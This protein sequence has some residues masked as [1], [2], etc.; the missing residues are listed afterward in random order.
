[1]G[2][3]NS[4]G[5]LLYRTGSAGLE[6]L[7]VHPGGPFWARRDDGAWSIPKGEFDATEAPEAAARREFAE[8]TGFAQPG[9]LVALPL[10]AQSRGK[11][12]HAFAAELDVDPS[13][14][15][16]NRFEIEWP[17]RSGR[18]QS[19]PEID[20]AGWFTLDAA[21]AKIV[22]GQRPILDALRQIV[23]GDPMQDG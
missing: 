11:V 21:R 22:A 4:A 20:R 7:L 9:G 5:V 2:A 14:L 8:E 13:A 12:V 10:V 3:A 19:F 6:V 18:R 1:M 16:S 15:R 17:P 23:G